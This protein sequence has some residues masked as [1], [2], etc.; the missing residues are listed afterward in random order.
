MDDRRIRV[1]FSQSVSK[2]K[3]KYG[4]GKFGDQIRKKWFTKGGKGG[5][6]LQ[7][8]VTASDFKQPSAHDAKYVLQF[9]C[10]FGLCV[11]FAVCARMCVSKCRMCGCCVSCMCTER[12]R[13]VSKLVPPP[14]LSH[15]VSPDAH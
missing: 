15:K 9:R 5:G 10:V 4:I 7:R 1:D 14:S 2:L 3:Q 8:M 12:L 6:Q 13:C 11:W